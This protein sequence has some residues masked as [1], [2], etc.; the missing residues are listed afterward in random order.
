LLTRQK[1][2]LPKHIF[3][4][5]N[6]INK[7]LAGADKQKNLDQR[8]KLIHLLHNAGWTY[9]SVGQ[10]V[11]VS[12][13]RVRQILR[14]KTVKALAKDVEIPSPPLKVI[15]EAKVWP[16]PSDKDLNRLLHL[17]PKAQLVRSSSP[18]FRKEAE[19]YTAL[20]N[21]VNKE[22]GVSLY[23]IARLLGIT[24]AAVYARLIRYGYK[25]AGKGESGVYNLIKTTNRLLS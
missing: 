17:Q 4:E 15:R 22:D 8:N 21:K 19:E 12:R 18:K 13:E 1:H 3:E 14:G 16:Q 10:A 23:R 5:F 24:Y 9:S 7:G 20:I 6:R 25:P 11:G 2:T